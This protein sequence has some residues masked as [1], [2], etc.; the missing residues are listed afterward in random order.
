MKSKIIGAIAVVVSFGI[1]FAIPNVAGAGN[2]IDSYEEAKAIVDGVKTSDKTK[3][4]ES[5]EASQVTAEEA[6][7]SE[8]SADQ[9][10]TAEN[11][12]AQDTNDEKT[13]TDKES[14]AVINPD[15]D[16]VLGFTFADIEVNG[17]KFIE[18]DY[19]S[20]LDSF[21][22]DK[23]KVEYTDGGFKI[24]YDPIEWNGKKAYYNGS[25]TDANGSYQALYW[26]GEKYVTKDL[27]ENEPTE[28]TISI[29]GSWADPDNYTD[30]YYFG[31][32]NRIEDNG[33]TKYD[34]LS[35]GNQEHGISDSDKKEIDN[36]ITA[37][38]T[39]G[40]YA[41]MNE[42]FHTDEMIEKGLKDESGSGEGHERYIVDTSIGKCSLNINTSAG[43]TGTNTYY[44]YDFENG[45][46]AISIGFKE[47][48]D[49]ATSI[50][51]NYRH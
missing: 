13:T 48:L 3:T 8:V 19:D 50:Q 36:Y 9:E 45:K 5:A 42:T 12:Q 23:T 24:D 7:S 35:M 6:S 37:P 1:G 30:Y 14:Q 11:T 44:Y 21:G 27:E 31:Y 4:S 32:T 47:G 22:F 49:S 18:A 43:G 33:N 10:L 17:D 41:A 51:Y 16:V 26:D 2:Q 38:F 34:Y 15:A 39:G 28:Y 46:Y 25:Y 20:I 40:D 29:S